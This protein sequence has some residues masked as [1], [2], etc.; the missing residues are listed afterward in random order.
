MNPKPNPAQLL[1][2]IINESINSEAFYRL[3]REHELELAP[4]K[5]AD[6]RGFAE[7][8]VDQALDLLSRDW[9]VRDLLIDGMMTALKD[10]YDEGEI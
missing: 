3:V 1:A 7:E 4:K 8:T 6:P 10:W 2:D 5:V 9:G